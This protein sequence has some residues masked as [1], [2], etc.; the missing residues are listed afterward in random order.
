MRWV[1]LE[2]DERDIRNRLRN[3]MIRPT[4]IPQ[5][6]DELMIEQALCRE[7]LRL[8][9]LQHKT[10]ATGLKGVQQQRTIADL[11]SQAAGGESLV[12]MLGLDMLVGSGGVLSH[13]PRRSQA[14]LMMV[15]AFQPEGFTEL[16]VDSIF[17]MPQLGVLSTVNEPAAL[18]VFHK[19][20]LI[21]L[22]WCIAPRGTGKEGR[23]CMKVR[24]HA[25]DHSE[26]HEIMFGQ[27][28]TVPLKPDTTATVTA[29][30][31]KGFD[32]GAGSGQQVSRQ[33]SGGVVGLVMDWRG[34]PFA[35][36]QDRSARVGKL[37]EWNNALD[38]FT[39]ETPRRQKAQM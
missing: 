21:R 9:F 19:D 15:D 26:E 5:T 28:R 14:A 35:P 18:D 10:M 6:L 20:C 23:P 39:A 8:A 30:P 2:L 33:I 29:T 32:M 25:E 24:V 11:F 37:I 1:P 31:A 34:R 13:A 3:K 38:A 12:D 4:T 36:P 7:A 17:M 22:G 27:I 16:T